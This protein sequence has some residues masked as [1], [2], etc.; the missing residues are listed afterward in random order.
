MKTWY[1]VTHCSAFGISST[2]A[3]DYRSQDD[4]DKILVHLE[5]HVFVLV[6]VIIP[7]IDATPHAG[8]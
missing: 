7:I 5:N 2:E 1:E 4:N 3:S 8:R 6:I